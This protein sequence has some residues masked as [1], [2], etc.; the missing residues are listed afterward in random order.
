MPL[1]TSYPLPAT[2]T[3]APLRPT[4]ALG[5]TVRVCP[6]APRPVPAWAGAGSDADTESDQGGGQDGATQCSHQA[7]HMTDRAGCTTD[8]E[9][10]V[11]LT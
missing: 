8:R 2:V 4:P 1:V 7:P 10:K 3:F 5:V 6:A 11:R 9:L